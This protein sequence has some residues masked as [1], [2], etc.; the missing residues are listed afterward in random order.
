MPGLLAAHI[1]AVG[2]HMLQHITIANIGADEIQTNV[3][4]EIL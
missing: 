2:A 3:F 1:I 4:D